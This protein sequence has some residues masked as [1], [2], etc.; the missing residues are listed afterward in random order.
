[1]K[2]INPDLFPKP[3]D[4]FNIIREISTGGQ[5]AILLSDYKV[6]NN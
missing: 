2:T 1:M 3:C 6:R 5:V 4:Y